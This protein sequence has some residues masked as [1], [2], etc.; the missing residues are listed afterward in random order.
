M[1]C[2]IPILHDPTAEMMP[3]EFGPTSRDLDC[4]LSIEC[5]W[6][7]DQ[8]ARNVVTSRIWVSYGTDAYHVVKGDMLSNRNHKGNLSFDSLLDGGG[9]LVGGHVDARGIR[10]EHLGGLGQCEFSLSPRRARAGRGLPCAPRAG[11]AGPDVPRH[12]PVSR[13]LQCWFPTP[14]T[15]WRWPLPADLDSRESPVS[16]NWAHRPHARTYP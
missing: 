7:L 2:S 12:G 15:L 6:N 9:G 13:R 10:L 11:V 16:P 5:I 14:T 4:V 8:S 1:R 3:G